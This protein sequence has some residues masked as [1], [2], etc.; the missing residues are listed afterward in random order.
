MSDSLQPHGLKPAR[1]LCPWDYA[2]QEYWSGL[3]FPSPGIF[4][5]RGSKPSL[6]YCKWILYHLYHQG[7]PWT[8]GLLNNR[9]L[10][11]TALKP[12]KSKMKA[13]ADL[14]SGESLLP[15]SQMAIFSLC[16]HLE[17][18]QRCSLGPLVRAMIPFMRAE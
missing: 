7:S 18:G 6:L 15:G 17:G 10:Y 11:L 16:A 2:R 5:T 3:P 12:G 8:Q 14:V 1:L 4:Q 9:N 13:S